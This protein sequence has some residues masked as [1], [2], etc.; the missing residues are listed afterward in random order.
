MAALYTRCLRLYTGARR[1]S[2]RGH[3][4][5]PD[6]SA[7]R[8]TSSQENEDRQADFEPQPARSN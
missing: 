8:T 2:A 5:L 6:M 4:P 3:D 1:L 7:A